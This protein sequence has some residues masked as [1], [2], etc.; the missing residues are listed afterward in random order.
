LEKDTYI[1][2]AEESELA[3]LARLWYD[4]WWEAHKPILPPELARHRTLENFHLRLR[5]AHE[6]LRTAGPIG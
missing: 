6:N 2:R 3:E 1:R 5:S 4:G